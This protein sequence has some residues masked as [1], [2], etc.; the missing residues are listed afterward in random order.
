MQFAPAMLPT[1]EIVTYP[2]LAAGA[3]LTAG[4]ANTYGAAVELAPAAAVTVDRRVVS[5][6]LRTPSAAQTGKI[7]IVHTTGV[8]VD[9]AEVDYEIASDAGAF[10]SIPIFAGPVVPAGVNIGARIKTTAGAQTV[11]ASI[12]I[13]NA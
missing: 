5:V 12:G 4:A 2:V 8:P 3:T 1:S 6:T 13:C 9:I 10:V 11:D 7:Q